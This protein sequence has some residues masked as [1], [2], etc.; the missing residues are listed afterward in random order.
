MRSIA[1]LLLIAAA[2]AAKDFGNIG[3]VDTT[4]GSGSA[5]DVIKDDFAF[6]DDAAYQASLYDD[7]AEKI[8]ETV[9]DEDRH[10]AY[11]GG[12]A[13]DFMLNDGEMG[14]AGDMDGWFN[15]V[16]GLPFFTENRNKIWADAT[17]DLPDLLEVCQKGKTCREASRV[18]L[19]NKLTNNWQALIKEFKS[20]VASE[21]STTKKEIA[22]THEEFVQCQVDDHCCGTADATIKNWWTEINNFTRQMNTL[23]KEKEVLKY[24]ITEVQKECPQ[25]V[26]ANFQ[27]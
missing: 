16:S 2:S 24:K 13:D 20:Q 11:D 25:Y 21:V 19:V 8:R 1:A 4:A 7:N 17:A 12:D 9:V 14:T 10:G 26:D 22:L 3:S 18:E 27:F 5:N 15:Q 23:K 6:S